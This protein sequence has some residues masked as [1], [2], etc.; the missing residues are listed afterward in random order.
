MSVDKLNKRLLG[1]ILSILFILFLTTIAYVE[2]NNPSVLFAG[3]L[4]L[5]F[6]VAAEIVLAH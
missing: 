6:F 2:F 4:A 5:T 1:D 3:A